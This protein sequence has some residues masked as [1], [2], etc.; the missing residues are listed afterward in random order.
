MWEL[1]LSTVWVPGVDH[2]RLSAKG[3][4]P[5]LHFAGLL[6]FLKIQSI[7]AELPFPS[8]LSYKV[9]SLLEDKRNN[10]MCKRKHRLS[11]QCL[12]PWC[13]HVT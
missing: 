2:V 3:L 8:S 7:T 13:A 10:G 12:V 11:A 6:L 5:L 1:S 4:Y 9:C